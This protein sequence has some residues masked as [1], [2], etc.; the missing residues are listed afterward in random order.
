MRRYAHNQRSNMVSAPEGAP[1]GARD[2]RVGG[3]S[4]LMTAMDGAGRTA[5][6]GLRA[7][8]SAPR[9]LLWRDRV[10]WWRALPY[11]GVVVLLVGI[12]LTTLLVAGVDRAV[13]LPNPGVVYLPLIAMLAYHWNW[14]YGALAGLLQLACMYV[15]FVPPVGLV[16]RLDAKT[17]AA[18]IA[19]AAVTAFMLALVQLAA[20]RRAQAEREAGRFAALTS[21]GTALAGELHEGRLLQLIAHTARE[22]TGAESAAFTLRPEDALGQPLVPSEGAR[23]H[24]AAVVVVSHEQETLFER[25]PLGGEGLLAPIFRHGVPVRV[26]DV[27]AMQ[28]GATPGPHT[29]GG[30]EH[31]FSPKMAARAAAIPYAEGLGASDSLRG[32]GVPRGH[33]VVRSFLGAPL[34]DHNGHVRGGLLLGHSA[35]DQF[36]GEHEELLLGLAAQAAVALEN[37]RLYQAAQAQAQELDTIFESIADAV[38]VVDGDG[39]ILRENDAARQLRERLARTPDGAVSTASLLREPVGRVLHGEPEHHVPV[40]VADDAGDQRE[41]LV[42]AFPLRPLAP[43]PQEDAT[44]DGDGGGA[45]P[46][47]AER[48]HAAVVIWHDVTETRRLAIER[49]ARQAAE[50]QWTLLRSIVEELPGAVY[51][52]RGTDARL[53]LA[54]R[55]AMAVWGAEWPVG[56]PMEAFLA[57]S[58]TRLFAPDGQPLHGEQLATL[59]V[60]RT[61]E[62]VHHYQEIIQHADGTRLPVLFNAVALDPESIADRTLATPG[63]AVAQPVALVALQDVSALKEAERLKDEFIT[64]AAHELRTPMTAIKGYASLLRKYA[65]QESGAGLDE[66]QLEAID[67]ID[68]STSR[69]AELTEDLLDVTRLQAGRLELRLEAHDLV[70]LVRRVAKRLQVT[71]RQHTLAVQEPGEPAIVELDVKR[72]EQVLGNLLN[73]AIKYSPAG[74]MITISVRIE[75][76]TGQAVVS[77]HDHGI[78]IPRD[79]QAQ[80]FNR[81]ARADNARKAGIGGTGLGLYLCRELVERQGGRIWFESDEG[82]GSTFYVSLPL[83]VE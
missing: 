60:L 59:R 76:A 1:H 47:G 6:Q 10:Q 79:Q 77:I 75:Q 81:F 64:I 20:T 14:R 49:D 36:T 16:K 11:S 26:P 69:L 5:R 53:G 15:F 22:L 28:H 55:A 70:A 54:N 19:L 66:L 8:W 61:E 42:R 46:A 23:F 74:G 67:T 37:A 43:A 7:L 2:L 9:V 83:Y 41:L 27:L 45:P 39:A 63:D 40:T 65:V 82:K 30:E 62:P 57:E 44:C 68:Q 52:V 73:N 80:L 24:L 18:L 21:I 31:H 48:P 17:L 4:R 25:I 71:T 38:A 3:V 34:L 78:G 56:Q 33:P 32:V 51:L 50:A 12:A 13:P 29:I 35:P 58:G 72:F